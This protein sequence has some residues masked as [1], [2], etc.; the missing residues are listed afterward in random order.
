VDT[1]YLALPH[2]KSSVSLQIAKQLV[3]DFYRMDKDQVN[4]V[5]EGLQSDLKTLILETRK[6]YTSVKEVN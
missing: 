5:I 3:I 2:Y 1:L 6:K 4:R